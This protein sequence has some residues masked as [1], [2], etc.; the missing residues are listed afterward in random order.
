[1]IFPEVLYVLEFKRRSIDKAVK[2]FPLP[3][4]PTNPTIWFLAMSNEML[5]NKTLF[6]EVLVSLTFSLVTLS[7]L[8]FFKN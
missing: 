7:K 2:D 4:S 6:E 3:D 5:F 1:M 8:V